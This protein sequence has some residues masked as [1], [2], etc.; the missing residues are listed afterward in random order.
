MP[1]QDD[2]PIF[3]PRPWPRRRVV[4]DCDGYY[5]IDRR[6]P[7]WPFWRRDKSIGYGSEAEAVSLAAAQIAV[8]K[9]IKR[10]G[11]PRV[12]WEG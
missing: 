8:Q 11:E 9:A 5:Y 1:D 2:P 6:S 10:L 7:W 4:Q 3:A 12:V